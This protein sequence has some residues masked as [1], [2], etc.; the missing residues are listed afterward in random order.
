MAFG[1]DRSVKV[2][3]KASVSDYIGKIT[4]ASKATKDF[5]K[6]AVDA[7][8]K[9][10]QSFDKVGA[11]MAITG[12]AIGAAVGLAVKSFADFDKELS[13]VRAV[14]GATAGQMDSLRSAALK[15][16]ADTKYSASEAAKAEAELAKV[17]ISTSDILGGALTG[18]LNLAAAGN[19]DLASA[20]EISGQAM[21]I[22]N[23]HGKDVGHI[24]DVLASGANKSAADVSTLGQALQ[25]GGLVAAQT[26]LSLEDTV[27]TL[28][29]FADNALQSS[30]AGTSLKTMLQRLTPQSDQAA[31]LQRRTKS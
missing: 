21:K 27:G 23:L 26:G 15:A 1:A 11:G 29:A 4:A 9:H 16:G 28:S 3:L 6:S 7:G 20:A 5:S 25:Q 8:A 30:D 2:E 10:K 12:A 31:L 13:N 14:S 19:I 24:A 18:S 17:G 22:F